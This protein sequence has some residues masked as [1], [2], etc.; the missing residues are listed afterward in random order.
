MLYRLPWALFLILALVIPLAAADGDKKDAAEKKKDD[1]SEKEDEKEPPPNVFKGKWKTVGGLV[2]ILKKQ[3]ADTL[4]LTV[5]YPD[6]QVNQKALN[7]ANNQA[8]R[9]M[10]NMQRQLNSLNNIRNPTQK[11]ARMQQIMMQMQMQQM[12]A[13]GRAGQAYKMV[14]KKK[15]MDVTLAHEY[16]VRVKNP[17]EEF[18]DKGNKKKYT[19]EE[20]RKLKGPGKYWGYPSDPGQ[21]R[22]GDQLQVFIYRKLKGPA[23]PAS[24]GASLASKDKDKDKDKEKDEEAKEEEKDKGKLKKTEAKAAPEPEEDDDG[25]EPLVK[26]I[27][28]L[29]EPAT[30]SNTSPGGK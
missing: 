12:Q 2:G 4:T 20:L 25:T 9:Q 27:Y 7:N 10:Q 24:P 26:I 3:G 18:D 11:M 14:T 17:P 23:K 28:I 8:N 19:A 15:D 30:K 22:V 13:A 5:E 1:K 6:V 16:M 21:I 29:R